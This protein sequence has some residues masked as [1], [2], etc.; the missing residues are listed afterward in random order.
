MTTIYDN[1]AYRARILHLVADPAQAGEAAVQYYEDGVLWIQTDISTSVMNKG[2]YKSIGNNMMLCAD[3]AS[4]AL[5]AVISNR[6]RY[7]IAH[8][9]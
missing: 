1:R 2:P 8:L 6:L 5:V 7:F 3:P 9:S 4:G